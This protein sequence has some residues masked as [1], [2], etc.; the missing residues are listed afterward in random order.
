MISWD[1]IIGLIS[2]GIATLLLAIASFDAK[3]FHL[4]RL[5][6]NAMSPPPPPSTL[7]Y[8]RFA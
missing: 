3:G 8:F 5:D 2:I 7:P 6:F 4:I 1:R